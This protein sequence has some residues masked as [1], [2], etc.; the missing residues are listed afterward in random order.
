M[1]YIVVLLV[2]LSALAACNM[3]SGPFQG[4]EAREV[5]VDGSTYR[6]FQRGNA[7]QA[8][9]VNSELRPNQGADAK[10]RR[11]IQTATGCRVVGGLSGDVVMANAKV[12]C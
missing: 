6:V 1:R 7:A 3:P 5:T 2:V 9:R 11:A 12:A 10:I 8:L 4:A